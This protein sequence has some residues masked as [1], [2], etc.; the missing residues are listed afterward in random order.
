[1]EVVL[2]AREKITLQQMKPM[3][4]Y[5]RRSNVQPCMPCE[6]TQ[7]AQ[8]LVSQRRQIRTTS[9]GA[10]A[11]RPRLHHRM[12]RQE[13][14]TRKIEDNDLIVAD[15]ALPNDQARKSGLSM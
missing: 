14:Q 1:M 6:Q 13:A 10:S 4:I 8:H 12:G 9:L 2:I 11:G 5:V 15:R 3:K 7:V